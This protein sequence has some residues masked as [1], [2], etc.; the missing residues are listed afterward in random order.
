M[1]GSRITRR[2]FI[3]N[4]SAGTA[5]LVLPKCGKNSKQVKPNFVFIL[6]DDLGWR[7]VG[8]YGS[9]FYETP[10]I[11][12]LTAEG[13]RF[14]DAYAACPVCS[15]TRASILT[16]KHPARLN[17]TDWIDGDDPKDRKL[18][19]ARDQH[20]LPL[21]EITIAEAMKDAGYAT[22]FIGKWH[23]GEKGF[24]PENQGFDLNIAGHDAPMPSTYFYPYKDGRKYS[25]ILGL[26]G[27]NPGEYLTDRLTDE[28]LKFIEANNQRPFLLYLSHYA[29]HTPIE[30]KSELTDK[31]KHKLESSSEPTKSGYLPEGSSKTKQIQD[32]PQYA[33]MI[34]SIDESVGRIMGKLDEFGLSK[35]T[36]I[37]FM[38]DNGG[39]SNLPIDSPTSN[40]PLRAGK[41][42]LYEGGIRVPMIIK[43]PGVVNSGSVCREPVI[44]M[45][46]YPTMLEMAGLPSRPLQ[47]KDGLSLIPL[48]KEND[49]INRKAINWHYPHY[50]GSGQRPAGAIRVGNF[51]LIEWFED[52]HEELYNIGE[53]LSETRDLSKKMPEKVTRLKQML[54][55]WRQQIGAQM[56]QPN[57]KWQAK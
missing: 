45:D 30:S 53:D 8:S 32:D 6:I 11:D 41:G 23:L 50:H 37:I 49:H 28:S 4:I 7:D 3:K 44:S 29:V 46:F 43:W 17:I 13:M 47:H 18:L 15:P 57:P 27:G 51:K 22:G 56:P 10:N 16:G 52:G 34:Q 2:K 35:N 26:E 39:L 12:R 21:E 14:T 38:S 20:Q 33:G 54:H 5:A 48:L 42:W 55:N 1:N 31:Y 36:I 9:S 25:D 19:G 24:Y 40:I